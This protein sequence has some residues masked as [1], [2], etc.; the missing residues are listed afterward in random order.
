MTQTCRN[1]EFIWESRHFIEQLFIETT[2][3]RNY[4]FIKTILYYLIY[5]FLF[6]PLFHVNNF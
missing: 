1:N 2:F 4:F 6:L 3:E 5:F